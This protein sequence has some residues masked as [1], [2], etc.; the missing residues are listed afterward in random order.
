MVKHMTQFKMAAEIAKNLATLLKHI[1]N[2]MMLSIELSTFVSKALSANLGPF[3]VYCIVSSNCARPITGQVTSVTWPLIGWAY[4]ELIP[5]K[6]QKTDPDI[7][8][9]VMQKQ[10]KMRQFKC[11]YARVICLVKFKMRILIKT[12]WFMLTLYA[13]LVVDFYDM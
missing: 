5:S 8:N 7:W 1:N 13:I 6:R 10:Y 4:S 11:T 12:L 9:F 2:L 3:S